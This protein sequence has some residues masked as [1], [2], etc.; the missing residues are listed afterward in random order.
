MLHKPL[1]ESN[2]WPT[3]A[4]EWGLYRQRLE[5]MSAEKLARLCLRI[6]LHLPVA[7]CLPCR[8]P[9]HFSF[10]RGHQSVSDCCLW[11]A[12]TCL[13]S[14]ASAASLCNLARA[15]RIVNLPC[16]NV[17]GRLLY[18]LSLSTRLQILPSSCSHSTAP[19]H[20]SSS[21]NDGGDHILRFCILIYHPCLRSYCCWRWPF[22]SFTLA[23]MARHQTFHLKR[24]LRKL[25]S[26]G[27]SHLK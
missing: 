19:P 10:W 16:V 26:I 18:Q 21:L 27:R 17:F 4:P 13:K 6:W 2:S 7:H 8:A 22:L 12:I 3:R 14:L 9:V 15:W 11:F 23:L 5:R 1:S 20:R 24:H 25:I